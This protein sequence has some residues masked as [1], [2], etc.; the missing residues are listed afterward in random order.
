MPIVRRPYR[1]AFAAL[2]AAAFVAPAFVLRPALAQESEQEVKKDVPYVPT[3]QELVEKM[4]EMAKVTDKDV[5][6]DLGCGDGRMVVTAAKKY[7]ARGVGVDIDPQRIAESNANAKEAGVTDKVK[8][9][10]GDLFE[11]DFSET[12]VLTLYLLPS[13]NEKLR[14][15]IL[16]LKPGTR[17]VSHAFTMG[18]WEADEQAEV[19]GRSAYYWTVPA[20][21][22][23]TWVAT[24]KDGGEERKVAL[25]LEQEYQKVT[26]SAEIDG[27]KAEIKDAKLQGDKLTFALAT[28]GQSAKT[29]TCRIDGSQM[30]GRAAGAGN[31]DDAQTASWVA[32]REGGRQSQDGQAE[33]QQQNQRQRQGQQDRPRSQDNN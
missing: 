27:K 12:T 13:V 25:N 9:I 4:L 29:Y 8:F 5:V 30:E 32:R 1:A 16:K 22:E 18:D 2:L 21:V 24:V 15:K 17:V 14:P 20:N 33:Q 6:Y 3:P 31:A 19:E 11:M 7:G 28:D 23:G 10:K 26:G